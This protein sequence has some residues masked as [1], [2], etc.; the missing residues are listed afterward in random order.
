[1]RVYKGCG[2]AGRL[3]GNDRSRILERAHAYAAKCPAAVSGSD[4]HGQTFAVACAVLNGFGLSEDE[5]L[6]VLRRYNE[7][8]DPP[9]NER[10]L[11]HKINQAAKANHAK[12]QGHL[13]DAGTVRRAALCPCTLPQAAESETWKIER[14]PS[15]L[16]SPVP[17][18]LATDTPTLCDAFSPL[19]QVPGCQ[20]GRPPE[21]EIDDD[22]WRAVVASG[23]ALEEQVQKALWL[24]GPGCRVLDQKPQAQKPAGLPR[25]SP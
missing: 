7:R 24:F 5:T 11:R 3:G 14:K 9:W 20:V 21:I 23:L 18:I 15:P 19:I 13:L 10:E 2:S 12:P 16:Q 6:E 4:G 17:G 25:Q 8:C 1:M 22:S